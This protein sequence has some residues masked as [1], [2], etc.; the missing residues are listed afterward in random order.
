MAAAGA[1]SAARQRRMQPWQALSE[2]NDRTSLRGKLIT[3]LLAL[4]AVGLVAISVA[5]VMVLRTYLVSQDDNQLRQVVSAINS[6]D[7]TL[8]NVL[9]GEAGA[10]HGVLVGLQQPGVPLKS[11][12][13]QGGVTY[14]GSAPMQSLPSVPTSAVWADAFS[15]K[16]LTVPAQSGSDSWRIIAQP[17]TFSAPSST[18]G[19]QQESGTLVVGVDL[20]NINAVIGR[21]ALAE[22]VI[23]FIIVC[24]LGLAAVMV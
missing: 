13:S 12:G 21:L 8:G 4:V 7:I 15:G 17:I 1:D 22:L 6:G 20:G 2:L 14:G 3:A 19:F 9:P 24:I 11:S 5:S 16:L 10:V 23:G 18:G